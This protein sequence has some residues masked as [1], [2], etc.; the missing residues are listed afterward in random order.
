[1][2]WEMARLGDVCVRIVDGS[3]N[4]PQ[5]QKQYTKYMMLSSKNILDGEVTTVQP[6][7]LSEKHY[8]QEHART[9][10][11]AG[12]VLLTIVGTI[13]RVALICDNWE[14]YPTF[15]RSVAVLRPKEDL[16]SSFFLMYS[17]RCIRENLEKE[18]Q[19]NSQKGLY[20]NQIENITIPLPPL[21]EQRRIAAE[22]ER[23]FAAVERAK[24]AAEEQ[25]AAARRL[26]P[27]Y[28]REVFEGNEWDKV[29]LGEVCEQAIETISPNKGDEIVYID[30]SSVDNISKR[31]IA[32]SIISAKNAPS[33]AK[34][35]LKPNDIILSTVRP[36]L[37][38]LA[39]NDITIDKTIVA[40]TGFCVLRCKTKLD[41]RYLFQFCMSDALIN[42]LSDIAKGSS[43]PAVT[44]TD[45]FEQ[46]IPIPPIDEQRRIAAEIERQFAAVERAKQ[47]VME[48]LDTINALPAAILRQA[49]SG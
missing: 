21:D 12:D 32:M 16:L 42:N 10:V 17:L 49:F 1:M 24:K 28:L 33:R 22:I 44:N 25:L 26:N 6:R 9:Q 14:V 8:I 38:A 48:Q 2:S 19:G 7:Y 46:T 41:Y 27:A 31:I 35:I 3:H 5:A 11:C 36:N 13:G 23:Q 40:S 45:I 37:N 43:Y 30:I 39:M 20:L 4:P 29:K 18:A 15:Q 47:A 34:Q